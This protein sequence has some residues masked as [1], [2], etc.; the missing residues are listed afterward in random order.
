M[1]RDAYLQ[2]L[3][4]FTLTSAALH[5]GVEL[6]TRDVDTVQM[7]LLVA[8]RDDGFLRGSWPDMLRRLAQ[9]EEAHLSGTGWPAAQ[10]RET[11]DGQPAGAEQLDDDGNGG[12]G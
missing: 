2:T 12:S 1:E 4:R 8:Q 6:R 5:A 9:L 3:A 11:G 10:L 7:L